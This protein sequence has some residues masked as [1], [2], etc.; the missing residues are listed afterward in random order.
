MA[1]QGG[2]TDAIVADSR[3][4]AL[5]ALMRSFRDF[6]TAEDLYQE[7]CLRAAEHWPREGMPRDPLA[8]LIKVARN[9]GLDRIRQA[10]RTA[11]VSAEMVL[12]GRIPDDDAEAKMAEQLDRTEYKDDVLRLMFL[13]CHPDLKTHEQLALALKVVVGFSV[14]EI[15]R[16]FLVSPDTMQRRLS[17][18][19]QHAAA[20]AGRL[21]APDMA[22]RAARLNAVQTMIYLLFNEG[23]AAGDG[24]EHIRL[25]LCDEAIR[26]ARLLLDLFPGQAELMGLLALCLLQHARHTARIDHDG[27]LVALDDQDRSSWNRTMIAEGQTLVQKALLRGRPG[28]L[29]IQAAIAAVHCAAPRADDTDWAEIERLYAALEAITPGPVVRL[30]RAVAVSKLRGPQPALALLEPLATDLKAYR[31]YHAVRAQFL[32]DNGEIAAALSA[33]DDA[34]RCSATRQETDFLNEKAAALRKKLAS[35]SES[36]G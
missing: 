35:L 4:R 28:P 16:A 26:L 5:A 12:E 32:E 34:L 23:Y 15:A 21:E 19:K 33:V 22:E 17:R 10:R 1:S 2:I 13:C 18:A 9:A 8:W 11:P 25:P 14:E 20:V 27:R 30:N 29:Q 24:N 3:P 7:A 6:D 31:P 36:P